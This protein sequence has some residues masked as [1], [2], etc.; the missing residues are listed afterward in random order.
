MNGSGGTGADAFIKGMLIGL[1]IGGIAALFYAP[2]AGVETRNNV[3]DRWERIRDVFRAGEREA[4][5]AAK[6]ASPLDRENGDR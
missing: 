5:C 4:A 2:Q 3:K 1:V 6:E